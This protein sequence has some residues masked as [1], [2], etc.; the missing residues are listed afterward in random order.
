MATFNLRNFS[1]ETLVDPKFKDYPNGW[2]FGE[3]V[4]GKRHGQ[5]MF[6]W[7]GGQAYMGGWNND[8][9]SGFGIQ[10]DGGGEM[11]IGTWR[12]RF[13]TGWGVTF[14]NIAPTISFPL[15]K[16][17]SLREAMGELADDHVEFIMDE[18]YHFGDVH[19]GVWRGTRP[20]GFGT[21]YYR[22]YETGK[23]NSWS[24]GEHNKSERLDGFGVMHEGTHPRFQ[25]TDEL[26]QVVSVQG[27]YIDGDLVAGPATQ[28]L[29][30]WIKGSAIQVITINGHVNAN[31]YFHGYVDV[32]LDERSIWSGL[33]FADEDRDK[34]FQAYHIIDEDL[35]DTIEAQRLDTMERI[36]NGDDPREYDSS[37]LVPSFADMS[38]EPSWVMDV[39]VSQYETAVKLKGE[40]A[41]EQERLSAGRLKYTNRFFVTD[42]EDDV[43]MMH[44]GARVGKAGF[45]M[46]F[47]IAFKP[48]FSTRLDTDEDGNPVT[49]VFIMCFNKVVGEFEYNS[50]ILTIN[51]DAPLI[52]P[53][54]ANGMRIT[55]PISDAEGG[56]EYKLEVNEDYYTS[57]D[58]PDNH[59]TREETKR[60]EDEFKAEEEVE[61]E[62]DDWPAER[63]RTATAFPEE[64]EGMDVERDE[65]GNITGMGSSDPKH[66]AA[67]LDMF[68]KGA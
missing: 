5:G 65:D 18:D 37:Y 14:E 62:E 60:L 27:E 46:T 15:P 68:K 34:D 58:D 53:F 67:I 33:V 7:P 17:E 41:V 59:L 20:G 25:D 51:T 57:D 31:G 43:V 1:L 66:F 38:P 28:T 9:R 16:D 63:T 52:T 13:M 49:T 50:D 40:Q 48:T 24:V 22:Y 55:L 61:N 8:V 47:D 3:L 23:V 45:H 6:F 32:T 19:E 2:Y 44:D 12:N 35:V 56:F 39:M 30:Y 4:E 10:R 29:S 26:E 54:G 36:S 42:W 21:R 64:V 11:Q